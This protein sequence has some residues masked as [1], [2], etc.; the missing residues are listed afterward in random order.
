[1]K[2]R[3]WSRKTSLVKRKWKMKRKMRRMRVNKCDLLS[4]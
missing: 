2:R 3:A 4:I 1:V